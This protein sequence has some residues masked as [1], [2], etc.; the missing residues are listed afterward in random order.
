MSGNIYVRLP[1]E[2]HPRRVVWEIADDVEVVGTVR[3]G[4]TD[5]AAADRL[6]RTV[7]D[8]IMQAAKKGTSE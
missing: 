7:V 6:M 2:G 4:E 1:A 5:D 3:D 8:T